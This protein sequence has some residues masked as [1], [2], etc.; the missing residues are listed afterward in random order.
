MLSP[1]SLV[2]SLPIAALFACSIQSMA[3][4]A[5]ILTPAQQAAGWTSLFDGTNTANFRG[6]KQAG[7][8]EKGWAIENGTLRS[9]KGQNGGDLISV[10]QYEDFELMF[11][12][13]VE[14]KSNSGVM[15]RVTETAD[16]TW[17]TGPEF[18]VL[19]DAGH[20]V[21]SEDY[22]SVGGLYELASPPANKKVV[23]LGEWNQARIRLAGGVLQHYLNGVK[24][25]QVR[26]DGQDWKDRIAKSKFKEYAG[27]GVQ[28]KGH[29]AIQ[30][31]GDSV[32]Y[33]NII[34]RDLSSPR[35]G[36]TALFNGKDLTGWMPYLN[37]EGDPTKTW[38][39]ADGVITCVGEPRGYIRTNNNFTNFV[40]TLNW[41]FEPGKEGNSG[42][43]L[44]GQQPDKVWPRSIEAQLQSG[45]AG[46]FWNIDKYEM[47]AE[48]SRTK[49][50]N[51]KHTHANEL[52]VGEWNHY[53][54]IA[55]NG[56][57]TLIVNGEVVN[58][59]VN[60]EEL[61]G[62]I[63]LQSEGAPIMFKNIA[64]SPI[65]TETTKPTAPTASAPK[66][67]SQ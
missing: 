30:D 33:R 56:N 55:D 54:I 15:Y 47:T 17:Q 22:H 1:Q 43:L 8:P 49:G 32:W 50:R 2:A 57:V 9:I 14:S 46:D 53:E 51:T 42:V 60:C 63:A 40:L 10:K 37:G 61:S 13:K 11:E 25:V 24:V 44:R 31:H 41:R 18:Q 58:S 36:E 66:P 39:I 65:G 5:N 59:A 4:D 28:P 34:I 23:Q 3:S 26:V 21:T 38:T 16:T 7:F 64:L 12:F 52:P 6:Y 19:D 20:N 35:P 67:V 62:F 48:A 29:I 27:F 45:S